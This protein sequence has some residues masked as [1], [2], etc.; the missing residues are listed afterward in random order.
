MEVGAKRGAHFQ[1]VR[2]R[3]ETKIVCKRFCETLFE[4]DATQ[5]PYNRIN[6]PTAE[7]GRAVSRKPQLPSG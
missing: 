2:G 4:G 3:D 1:L 7:L 5:T 6:T